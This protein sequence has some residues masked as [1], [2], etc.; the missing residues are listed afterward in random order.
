MEQ[1]YIFGASL[2]GKK[3]YELLKLKYEIL[4]FIDND[5]LKQGK[6]LESLYIYNAN[7]IRQI[8]QRIFIAT[9]Y[10]KEIKEQLKE[11]GYDNYQV[12]PNIE[13]P[14]NQIKLVIWD[15][16]DTFWKGTLSEENIEIIN[17][18]IELV[19]SLTQ[20]GILNS[21]CSK[22]DLNKVR[23]VLEKESIW[24]YFIFPKIEWSAKGL[25]VKK[26]I[27]ESNLRNE[28]VLFID[29]NLLNIDEVKYYNKNINAV[30]PEYASSILEREKLNK[31][32]DYNFERLKN[33]KILENQQKD[34][35]RFDNNIQFLMNSDINIEINKVEYTVLDRIM[36]LIHRTN[37]LN[38]TKKRISDNEL[39]ELINNKDYENKYIK[40]MDKY[41]NYGIIGFYSLNVK[42]QELKHFLFSCRAMNLG[43]EQYVYSR[44]SF[45][46]LNVVGEVA[47]KLNN[48]ESPFWIKDTDNNIKLE[49]KNTIALKKILIK[50]GCDLSQSIHYIKHK[51][52]FS[53]EFNYN[54]GNITMFR[55]H[56]MY[57]VN[58]LRYNNDKNINDNESHFIDNKIYKTDIFQNRHDAIILSLLTDYTED[59]YR[60]ILDNSILITGAYGIL[61]QGVKEHFIQYES[62]NKL[63]KFSDKYKYIGQITAEEFINNLN[64][65]RQK[66]NNIPLI[67]IN[68]AEIDSPH[69][70]EKGAKDRHSMMNK[71]LDDFIGNNT[72]CY[73]IDV[74]AIVKSRDDIEENIRHYKRW[75]YS[76]IASEIDST[77]NEIF[78]DK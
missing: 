77:L 34:R 4:G 68:G 26:I 63:N 78:R 58:S 70:Q 20:K 64:I 18:N 72:N 8:N 25:L 73:L 53:S 45:P 66:T 28:N 17:E 56:S 9:M 35:L 67:F 12:F 74:R 61:S 48:F 46:K 1:I 13:L 11:I 41:G 62:D 44:L 6:Y 27:E 10:Y 3:A 30:L 43:I 57:I 19:K 14:N 50:G 23:S 32:D 22:N 76:F 16:D 59:L 7:I 33:Y 51:Y 55:N 49:E 69:P 65:I 52:L 36:A 42:K 54:V 37:Q 75:V 40:L 38:F 24:E 2:A 15:L 21:I 71:L 29:D 60:N 47:T 39:L 5:P 31:K